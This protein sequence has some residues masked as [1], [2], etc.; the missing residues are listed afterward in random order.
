MSKSE[1]ASHRSVLDKTLAWSAARDYAGYSKHDAL[2]S[3]ILAALTFDV[4]FLRLLYIQGVMRSPINV[5]PLCLVRKGRNPK[6]VGLFAHAYFDL[7]SHLASGEQHDAAVREGDAL[8]EWLVE[9]PSPWTTDSASE[10]PR[11]EGMGWGYHYPWQDVGFY[12]PRHFPNRVV[13][14][15]IGMAFCRGYEVTQNDRYLRAVRDIVTFLLNNPKRLVETEDQLCLSYVPVEDIDW[16]VM[17]VSALVASLCARLASHE[18]EPSSLL[19]DARRLMNFVVDKQTDYGAW[20]YTWPEGDSHIRHD[21]YHTGIILDA[22][23]D[24]MSYSGDHT[25]L[26]AYQR[27]LAYYKE[28]LFLKHGAPR[29]MNDKTYPHDIHGA[30]AGILAFTRAT[31]YFASEAPAANTK[32]AQESYDFA[33]KILAWTLEHLHDEQGYFY[34]Q[35]TRGMTKKLCLMRWCNAWMCR[36]IAQL[37]TTERPR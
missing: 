27:G 20:F 34:Y 16:A 18:K 30:A 29:W 32:L 5:R 36:A 10:S 9:H 33:A 23:A 19:G 4:R 12:Q 25:H 8:L 3:P 6:G 31:R 24:F 13:S 7:A 26:D 15:W 28:Q 14:S 17:D 11:L 1:Q 35:Q 37:V 21:N 2:N 22:L